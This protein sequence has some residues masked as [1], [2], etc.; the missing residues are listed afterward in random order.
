MF[1]LFTTNS[2]SAA[3]IDIPVVTFVSSSL[4][5]GIQRHSFCTEAA[6]CCQPDLSNHQRQP[7][8]LLQDF[9]WWM[10]VTLIHVP[11]PH[12]WLFQTCLFLKSKDLIELLW[13]HQ[14]LRVPSEDPGHH[15]CG[16]C[17]LFFRFVSLHCDNLLYLS[18]SSHPRRLRSL[19]DQDSSCSGSSPRFVGSATASRSAK[20]SSLST[21]SMI[22]LTGSIEFSSVLSLRRGWFLPCFVLPD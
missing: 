16:G 19:I 15:P 20:T 13:R 14:F 6:P 18:T 12:S 11:H 22:T 10:Q 21:I 1:Y 4:S 8:F 17:G 9:V 5:Q 7:Q 2:E 3:R